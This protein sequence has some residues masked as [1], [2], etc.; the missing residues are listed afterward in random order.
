MT[1]ENT[2]EVSHVIKVLNALNTKFAIRS[3]GHKYAP[4]F[5][6]ID[7][8]GVLIALSKLNSVNLNHDKSIATIG[9]GLR[10]QEVYAALEPQGKVVAGGRVSV[11]GV[12]G[13]ILGGMSDLP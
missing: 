5:A 9:P 12:G 8:H 11:V 6:S 1:P 3:G 10:W 4:G 2:A 13:L 7:N